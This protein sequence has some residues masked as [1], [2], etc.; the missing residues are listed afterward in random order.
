MY[1]Q[2]LLVMI[3]MFQP[4][5]VIWTLQYSDLSSEEIKTV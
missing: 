4:P 5:T 2:N 3:Y 1:G